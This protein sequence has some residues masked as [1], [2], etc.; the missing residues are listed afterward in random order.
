MVSICLMC[1][2]SWL[3]LILLTAKLPGEKE[4]EREKEKEKGRD[5]ERATYCF[6]PKIQKVHGTL[7][8][9]SDRK[10]SYHIIGQIDTVFS[11]TPT[12]S[13]NA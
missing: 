1:T 13:V 4:R 8:Y 11:I 10:Q 3:Y 5:R 7:E 6:Y 12:Y 9:S 2:S